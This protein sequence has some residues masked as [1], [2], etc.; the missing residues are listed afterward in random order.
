[1]SE[2]P[3]SPEDSDEID[4]LYR[5]ASARDGSRPSESV[6]RAVLEHAA[7]L[8]AN[9]AAGKGSARS[10]SGL[11]A[12]RQAWWRPAALGTLAAA[13]LAGFLVIPQY[14]GPQAPISA[15]SAPTPETTPALPPAPAAS[16]AEVVQ[17]QAVASEPHSAARK[18]AQAGADATEEVV[19]SAAKKL[20]AESRNRQSLPEA[21]PEPSVA[22]APS[23]STAQSMPGASSAQDSDQS[24]ARSAR[25]D[26]SGAAALS[27]SPPPA[28]ASFTSAART[29]DSAA[30]LRRAAEMG[31]VAVLRA[32]LDQRTPVDARDA[33]GRTALMLAT[34]HGRTE[35]VEALLSAGADPNAADARGATPLQAALAGDQR[36]IAAALRR[37][38][39][40]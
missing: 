38:G 34:L 20:P 31:D 18:E 24:A 5:R 7:Q 1:V 22:G 4:A 25:R 15:T 36:A 6:R 14:L 33:S 13:A 12:K 39:A 27:Y 2:L 30:Q 9:R 29:T 10:G 32:L 37:A 28:P 19:V 35:A 3:P 17:P 26:A 8:A 21:T 11:R 16:P 23:A 40:R